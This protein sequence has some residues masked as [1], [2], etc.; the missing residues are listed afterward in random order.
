MYEFG[1]DD[2]G[3]GATIRKSLIVQADGNSHAWREAQER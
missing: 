1:K 2:I 3:R